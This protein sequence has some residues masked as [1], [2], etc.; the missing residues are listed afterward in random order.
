MRLALD[1]LGEAE[2]SDVSL[3]FLLQQLKVARAGELTDQQGEA[4]G[5]AYQLTAL[6]SRVIQ[7]SL[8]DC[9]GEMKTNNNS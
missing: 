3:S 6:I 7:V 2:D 9:G 5:H 8:C 4:F 1:S